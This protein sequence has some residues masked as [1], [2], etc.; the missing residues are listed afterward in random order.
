MQEVGVF[1]A[2]NELAY[3]VAMTVPVCKLLSATNEIR[4]ELRNR[5]ADLLRVIGNVTALNYEEGLRELHRHGSEDVLR[6][7]T[8]PTV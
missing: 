7:S 5:C 8:S 1:V 2:M 6:G 3:A 4:V